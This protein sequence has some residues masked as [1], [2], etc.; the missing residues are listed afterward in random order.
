MF[1]TL[2]APGSHPA[3]VCNQRFGLR[4]TLLGGH[5]YSETGDK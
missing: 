3:L 4:I 1:D 5:V 2:S